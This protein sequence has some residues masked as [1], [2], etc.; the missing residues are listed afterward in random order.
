VRG[1]AELTSADSVIDYDSG[2]RGFWSG[3]RR[4]SPFSLVNNVLSDLKDGGHTAV[5]VTQQG[6][7]LRKCMLPPDP[8]PI[9]SEPRSRAPGP[10]GARGASGAVRSGVRRT[11]RAGV[12][13]RV[14]GCGAGATR[15]G[16]RMS[17]AAD[18]ARR[19][20]AGVAAANAAREPVAAP[21]RH[22]ATPLGE[23]PVT[24][25]P[26]AGASAARSLAQRGGG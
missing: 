20:A 14:R 9:L 18:Q 5:C 7:E 8:D 19:L 12:S 16:K 4:Q 17:K 11:G 21:R 24:E 1:C 15:R 13:E 26:A 2:Y 3:I 10:A 22:D 23:S 25:R 6:R